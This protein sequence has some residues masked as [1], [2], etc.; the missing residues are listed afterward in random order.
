MS[1]TSPTL[2]APVNRIAII[3]SFDKTGGQP[4]TSAELIR[5]GDSGFLTSVLK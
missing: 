2:W 5:H 1:Q 3:A 4:V